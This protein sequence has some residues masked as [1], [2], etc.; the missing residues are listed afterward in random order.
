MPT[1]LARTVAS[2]VCGRISHCKS[3]TTTATTAPVTINAPSTR[4]AIRRARES[5]GPS[6]GGI[7]LDPEQGHPEEE[8][9]Q[10]R[11]ARIDEH[12]RAKVGIHAHANEEV[13]RQRRGH[14]ADRGTEHP[15]GEERPD[16]VDL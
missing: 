2:S 15:R 4:P 16:D 6:S 1:K 11:E 7:R 3:V 10:D 14:D 5:P 8:G 13:S 9:D 12:S